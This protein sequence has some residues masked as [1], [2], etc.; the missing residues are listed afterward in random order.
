MWSVWSD[1]WSIRRAEGLAWKDDGDAGLEILR[2]EAWI[3]PKKAGD[4]KVEA[5]GHGFQRFRWFK[6]VGL[7]KCAGDVFLW[8]TKGL[9]HAQRLKVDAGIGCFQRVPAD[10][11]TDLKIGNRLAA[12]H[13]P[14]FILRTRK[15]RVGRDVGSSRC[16]I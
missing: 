1:A 9:P 10:E 2:R 16:A 14:L 15:G 13:N 12:L 11:I 4:G 3:G 7:W 6:R 8:N 5:Y